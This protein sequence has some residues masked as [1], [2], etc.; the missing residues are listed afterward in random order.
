MPSIRPLLMLKRTLNRLRGGA[1][2]SGVWLPIDRGILSPR[3]ELSLAAGRYEARERAMATR[4]IQPGDVVLEL[5]SGLGFISSYVRQC[6]GA[7][8]II[9]VEANPRLIPY[10]NNVHA[11]NCVANVE[12]LNRVVVATESSPQT[13][14]FYCRSDFWASSLSPLSPYN[15]VVDV[16]AVPFAEILRTHRPDVLIMDIEGGEIDLMKTPSLGSIRTVV[17]ETHAGAYGAAGIRALE[18]DI[19]R[20]GFTEDPDG[21]AR[22]VR[23]FLRSNRVNAVHL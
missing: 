1:D 7:G 18:D 22:D 14:P 20:L 16:P 13:F 6:T 10:I 5:G 21:A 19:A 11:L 12:V 2:V 3:M 4:V 9:C 8:K 17:V 23:T 15:R